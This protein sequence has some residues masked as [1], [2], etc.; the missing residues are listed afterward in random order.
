[1]AEQA[2][3]K[4]PACPLK[5]AGFTLL[6]LSEI[7]TVAVGADGKCCCTTGQRCLDVDKRD[8]MRCTAAELKALSSAAVRRRAWQ[9]GEDW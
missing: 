1:M 3:D 9:S 2:T 4:Y 8:G 5:A 6:H 7:G